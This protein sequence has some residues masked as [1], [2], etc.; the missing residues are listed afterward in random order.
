MMKPQEWL[1]QKYAEWERTQPGRQTYY[2][3]ARYLEVNHTDLTQWISGTA[4]PSGDDL[5]RLAG[6]LGNEIY[7]LMGINSPNTQFQHL[8]SAFSCLPSAL[9]QHLSSAFQEIEQQIKSQ[10]LDPESVE[11][12][13]ISVK[14]LAKWGFHISG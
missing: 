4:V 10:Q 5:A 2:H 1:D 9:R 12:K 13:R 3:F 6:K 11:A 7:D 8:A 14:T